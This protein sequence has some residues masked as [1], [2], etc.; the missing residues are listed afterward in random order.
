MPYSKTGLLAVAMIGSLFREP[1]IWAMKGRVQV[2][3]CMAKRRIGEPINPV[4]GFEQNRIFP[5][6]PRS[7]PLSGFQN[8]MFQRRR[9]SHDADTQPIQFL[10][11]QCSPSRM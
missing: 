7:I 10:P 3:D 5:D 1:A 4:Q 11:W 2:E 6:R 9:D 8:H